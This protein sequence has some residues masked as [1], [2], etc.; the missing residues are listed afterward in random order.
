MAKLNLG[1]VTAYAD[2][3]KAGFTGTR[4]EFAEWLANAGK[5]AAAVA[6]N[7]EESK[8]VLANVNTAGE[9][10]VKAV[11]NEGAVQTKAVED[12]AEAK[13]T[14]IAGLDVVQFDVPQDDKTPA[15]KKQARTNIDAAAQEDVDSLSEAIADLFGDVIGVAGCDFTDTPVENGTI[16]TSNGINNDLSAYYD[17]SIRCV[18]HIP[19]YDSEL[20]LYVGTETGYKVRVYFY[21]ES[22]NFITVTGDISGTVRNVNI[23]TGAKYLRYRMQKTDGTSITT[24]DIAKVQVYQTSPFE[25]R[26]SDI[27]KAGF[28]Y[29]GNLN[30]LGYTAFGDCKDIGYY[31]FTTAY[32]ASITDKPAELTN[33]GNCYCF[34]SSGGSN[35]YWW[36]VVD[37]KGNTWQK[38]G[39]YDWVLMVNK[40]ITNASDAALKWCAMGDSIT[41]G[42]YSYY[43]EDGTGYYTTNKTETWCPLVA[44]KNNWG[45]TNIGQGGRGYV[46]VRSES[47]ESA[48]ALARRTDYTAYDLVTLAYGVNDWKGN[49]VIGDITDDGSAETPTTM[50]GGM[51]AVIEAIMASNPHIKIVVI[52]PI[53]SL[54]YN[55]NYGTKETNWGLG[56]SFSNSGTLEDVF[57]AIVSVCDYYGIEYIDMT[58][59]SC[60][61]R[62]NIETCLIDGVHPSLA[63]HAM[64]AS[65]LAKKINAC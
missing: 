30:T 61:N 41:E 33:S 26:I 31:N 13:K 65:E 8:K 35:T 60:I 64:M 20:T 12:A 53:N 63:A 21:D 49:A 46:F 32:L 51:K 10:Q 54:G 50:I 22:K 39:S 40:T 28:C 19:I 6:A 18:L 45:L 23:T 52:T 29:R 27:E 7:L 9:T 15:Q 36:F 34:P 48:Y 43:K 58:H 3:V 14:E 47:D 11:Q 56:H 57:E 55:F 59:Y 24:D 4:E 42:Y 16:D 5:N 38:Y 17:I 37:F 1:A 44:A 62:L 25:K 2:A